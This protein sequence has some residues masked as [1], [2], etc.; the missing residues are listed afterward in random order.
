MRD[1]REATP[2]RLQEAKATLE[3]QPCDSVQRSP[4]VG[5][6]V[7][8]G[9]AVAVSDAGGFEG[10]GADAATGDGQALSAVSRAAL[11][12]ERGSKGGQHDECWA[13]QNRATA[14]GMKTL[15]YRAATR[16]AL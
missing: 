15:V 9:R 5:S 13:F 16:K 11:Q 7:G 8:D 2:T 14:T 12:T 1:G 10:V 3:R 4:I 6:E